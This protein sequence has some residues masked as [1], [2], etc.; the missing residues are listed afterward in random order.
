MKRV[1][2]WVTSIGTLLL[3]GCASPYSQYYRDNNLG[4]LTKNPRVILSSEPRM[5]RGSDPET[6]AIKML[7]DGYALIGYSTFNGPEANDRGALAQ[8]KKVMASMVITYSKYTGSETRVIPITTPTSQTAMTTMN[9]S[10]FGTHGSTN[11]LGTATTTIYGSQTSM[12]PY[13]VHRSDQ[14]AAYWVKVKTGVVGIHYK[15]LTPDIVQKIGTNKGIL[16]TAVVRDGPA[17]HADILRNDVISKIDGTSVYDAQSLQYATSSKSGQDVDFTIL[18]N[19][20]EIV[21]KV[22]LGTQGVE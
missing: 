14:M 5:L 17:F 9:G 1:I 6:D 16:V 3:V 19:N 7:E 10:A 22:R 20:Q 11:Y 8:G 12:V 13:T 15:S 4:D 2:T 21:K 18:R